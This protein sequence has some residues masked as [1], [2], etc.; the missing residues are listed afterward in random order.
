MI[1]PKPPLLNVAKKKFV[2]LNKRV[3][4]DVATSDP[5][6]VSYADRAARHPG[7]I[8][9]ERAEQKHAKAVY[10]AGATFLIQTEQRQTEKK[11][12]SVSQNRPTHDVGPRVEVQ[13]HRLNLEAFVS[14]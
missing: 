6:A 2:S 9:R 7:V 11:G 10:D 14:S 5:A 13:R 8:A 4:I 1:L 12:Q 3:E